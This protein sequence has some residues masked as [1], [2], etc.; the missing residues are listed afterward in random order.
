MRMYTIENL[1][2]DLESFNLWVS[3]LE[4]FDEKLYFT[5]IASGKWSVSEIICH[6]SFWD[7]YII[8]EMLPIMKKDAVITG[9]EFEPMNQRAA[10]YALSG[11]TSKEL[12]QLQI[13]TRSKL[14]SSLK[15]KT[16]EEFFA[17][18]IYDGKEIDEYSGSPH[19][20][21]NYLCGFVWHDDHHKKQVEAFLSQ[22]MEK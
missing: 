18:F 3:S 12:I 6:I 19:S 8:E 7:R 10:E 11:F 15:K 21:F 16:E 2:D 1:I 14:L 4:N 22:Q 5:P 13:E 17:E 9:I 20:L